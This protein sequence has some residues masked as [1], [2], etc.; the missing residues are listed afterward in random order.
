MGFFAP[1]VDKARESDIGLGPYAV[2]V[3]FAIGVFFSTFVFNVFLMNLPVEG[4]PLEVLEIFKST[5]KQHLLGMAGGVLW[6]TGM[7]ASLAVA[8]APPEAHLGAAAGY[9]LAQGFA[10]VAALWGIL[11]WKELKGADVR[12]KTLAVCMFLLFAG[13]LLVISQAWPRV[14]AA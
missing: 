5:P 9:L 3:V 13:G 1:L 10:L 14:V 11:L 7:V 6:C 2:A 12:I 8:S 4:E